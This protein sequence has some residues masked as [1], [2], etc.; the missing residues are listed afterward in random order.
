[1]VKTLLDADDFSFFIKR[2]KNRE[3][4]STRNDS[5]MELSAK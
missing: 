5:I 3:F 2:D 4:Y 1:M